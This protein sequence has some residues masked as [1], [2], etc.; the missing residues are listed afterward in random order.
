MGLNKALRDLSEADLAELREAQVR[1]GKTIEYKRSL[2]GPTSDEKREFLADVSSFA[3][4][5]GG[6]LIFGVAEEEGLPTDLCGVGGDVDVDA[7]ILRLENLARDG[8]EPRLPVLEFRAVPLDD[9]G[10]AVV[11]RIGASWIAPH[12]VTYRNSA[13]FYSRTSA[14]KYQLSVSEIRSAV[15]L[16]EAAADRVRDFRVDRIAKVRAGDTSVVLG[17]TGKVMLQ[18]VPFGALGT[19]SRIIDPQQLAEARGRLLPLYGG[20]QGSRFTSMDS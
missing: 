12:M 7:E 3:N 19:G 6:H 13:K 20:I 9:R 15:L 17:S 4:A 5:G 8:V 2:P 16:S 14:G 1:E 10:P 11:T 18:I